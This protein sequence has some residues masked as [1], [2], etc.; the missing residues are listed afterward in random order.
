MA[1]WLNPS[2]WVPSAEQTKSG[3]IRVASTV[4]LTFLS[5]AF[6][7]LPGKLEIG[8]PLHYQFIDAGVGE[9]DLCHWQTLPR[10]RAFPG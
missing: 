9:E 8:T 2:P 3:I 7:V 10:R 1:L 5:E 4:Q 6:V